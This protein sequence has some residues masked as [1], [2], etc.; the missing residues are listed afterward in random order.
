LSPAH[1]VNSNDVGI[2]AVRYVV[3]AV[4]ENSSRLFI[5]AAF[6]ENS[7]H[8][9]HRSDGYV[10]NAEFAQIAKRLRP[11]HELQGPQLNF[12][13][14]R[15]SLLQSETQPLPDIGDVW[16]VLAEQKEQLQSDSDRL[17]RLQQ[18]LTQLLSG[19]RLQVTAARVELKS[20]PYVHSHLVEVL[21]RGQELVVL[22]QST[23]W[24]QVRSADGQ[25][26]WVRHDQV[27]AQR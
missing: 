11:P 26:G 15:A 6:I 2:V 21:A 7:R 9:V 4:G 5:E 20:A 22:S 18:R 17:Q 8:Q 16:R 25:E 3:L 27:E 12:S 14:E 10:E 23:F 1:F 24:F 19:R 13:T